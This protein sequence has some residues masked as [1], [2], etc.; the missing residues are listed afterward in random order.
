MA[1]RALTE[2]EILAQIPEARERARIADQTEPRAVSARY[3]RETGRVELELRNG[4]LF[5][6]PTEIVQDLRGA[7]PDLLA[8]VEILGDGYALRWEALD[9]DYTVPGLL[10]GRFGGRKWMEQWGGS[11]WNARPESMV[12]VEPPQ[13]IRRKKVS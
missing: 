3:N 10:E 2:Q 1:R 9:A 8:A 12:V 11:G 6:F 4:C 13:E 7:S 5:A